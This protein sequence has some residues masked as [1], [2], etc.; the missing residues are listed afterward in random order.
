[1]SFWDW[2]SSILDYLQELWRRKKGR[3]VFLGLDNAGKTTLL[4]MLIEGRMGQY[5]PT[6]HAHQQEAIVGRVA[7]TAI[8]LGGHPQVSHTHHSPSV[9]TTF[10]Y[11]VLDC[12][13]VF[14]MAPLVTSS[15][16]WCGQ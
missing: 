14:I 13:C 16:V 11:D 10:W 8:D 15:L 6:M 3:M 5:V 9:T 12:S 2:V 4:E 1:M 7:F